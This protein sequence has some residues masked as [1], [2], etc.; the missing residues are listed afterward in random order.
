MGSFAD[1]LNYLIGQSRGEFLKM[2]DADDICLPWRLPLQLRDMGRHPEID[3]LYSSV[4]MFG[5]GIKPFWIFPQYTTWL[6]NDRFRFLLTIINPV[7]HSTLI[8]IRRSLESNLY[9]DVPG[10]DL[11]LWLRIATYRG[12]IA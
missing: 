3:L 10:E 1:A 9:R 12:G 11:D 2:I 6:N 8:A 7:E 5:E 4:V